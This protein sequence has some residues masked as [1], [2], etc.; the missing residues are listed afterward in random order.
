MYRITARHNTGLGTVLGTHTADDLWAW[1]ETRCDQHNVYNMAENMAVGMAKNDV[2][3]A[4]YGITEGV[5]YYFAE[6]V[7]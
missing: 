7:G 6:L 4:D 3:A 5:V 1:L 2:A